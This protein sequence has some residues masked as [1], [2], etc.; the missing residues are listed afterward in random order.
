MSKLTDSRDHFPCQ[1]PVCIEKKFQ[2]FASELDLRA[3]MMEEVSFDL[4]TIS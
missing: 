1:Q 4:E 2:V 3:H